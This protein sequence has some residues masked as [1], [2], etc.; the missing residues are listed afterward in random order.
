M[1][2]LDQNQSELSFFEKKQKKFQ[3][4]NCLSNNGS[5]DELTNE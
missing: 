4:K 1:R 5:A 2:F 3:K